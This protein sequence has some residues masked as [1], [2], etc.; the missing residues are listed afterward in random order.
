MPIKSYLAYPA[1]GR[2]EAL[3]ESLAA[4]DGCDVFPSLN[5]ELLILVT[6]T[7][8]EPAEAWLEAQLQLVPDIHCLALVSGMN[9]DLVQINSAQEIS[10]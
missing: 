6:D 8:D 2:A 4:L 10:C 5:E 9:P 3:A 1:P 7:P